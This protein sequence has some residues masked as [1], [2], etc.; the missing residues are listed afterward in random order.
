MVSD[1]YVH[2]QVDDDSD[3]ARIKAVLEAVGYTVIR[4]FTDSKSALARAVTRLAQQHALTPNEQSV[5]KLVFDGEANDQ[6]SKTLGL[7]RA[8]VKWHMHN[9]FA[10]TDTATREDLLRLAL[11]LPRPATE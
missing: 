7:T 5:L 1:T 9:I 2:I 10:K 8:T 4:E 6:I 3:F 11:R